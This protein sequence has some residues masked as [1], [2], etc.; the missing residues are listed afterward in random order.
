MRT[1]TSGQYFTAVDMPGDE[2]AT[3]FTVGYNLGAIN[4]SVTYAQAKD[5]RGVSGVES[6][7]FLARAAV[8]F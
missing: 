6:D 8:N 3:A 5:I 7:I 1:K 4:T 2:K